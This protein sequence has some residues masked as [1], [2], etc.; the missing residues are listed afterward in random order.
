MT[1]TQELAK[2]LGDVDRPGDF[3]ASGRAEFLA[4]RLEVAGVGPIALPLLPAQTK[5]LIKAARRAPY[6]RGSNTIVDTKVRRTWQIEASRVGI[7]GKH[8]A[9]TL[10]GIVERAAVG[11][12]VAEPVTAELYKLLVYDKG[13]FF[14]SHRDTEKALGMF[15]TLVLALPSQSKGGELVVRHEGRE[16]RLDLACEEPSEI[17]FAAF[18]ADCVHEV[19]PVTSGC[20]A[21]LVFNLL[22]RAQGKA[23]EPPSYEAEAEK[24][25][26]LLRG[27]ADGKATTAD[28]AADGDGA[29]SDPPEKL[30]IPLEHAYT[31][32]ELAFD[33]LKGADAAVA[34][35]L[36]AAAT[37]SWLRLASGSA[38]GLG[39][40]LGGVQRPQELALSAWSTR[41]GRGG[42][43][44]RVR[45]RRS[46]RLEQD[47]IGLA[48]TGRGSHDAR[49]AAD[50]GRRG[51]AARCTRRHGAGRGAFP[52]GDRQ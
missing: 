45:C 7:S 52:R 9:K 32:A 15:A 25:I 35:L 4:P 44:Q 33:K 37:A 46:A 42:G 41:R 23:P 47:A 48:P 12:G 51:V 19:L 1:I 20:R 2:I 26:Q 27:W 24:V 18:Y 38:H 17:A 49:Q 34:R 11:L 5:E 28:D 22:R 6:G 21:T 50:R 16:V 30:I 29:P 36:G 13:S 43:C 14:V 39:E 3:F 10:D 8:W 40:R 31:P